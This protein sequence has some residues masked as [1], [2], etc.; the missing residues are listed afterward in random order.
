MR[1]NAPCL[2]CSKCTCSV[3]PVAAQSATGCGSPQLEAHQRPS[4]DARRFFIAGL[5][6]FG[7][8]VMAVLWR[9][10][11]GDRKVRR[12]SSRSSNRA[13]SATSRLEASEA[14]SQILED[15][16]MAA[17]A[18]LRTTHTTSTAVDSR[19]RRDALDT[20]EDVASS[21]RSIR[22]LLVPG[23]SFEAVSRDNLALLFSLLSRQGEEGGDRGDLAASAQVAV[24]DLMAPGN[25]LHCVSRDHLCAL[26]ELLAYV[27]VEALAKVSGA[28]AE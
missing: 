26:V 5:K 16:D 22:D 18:A 17:A 6:R 25:D 15:T 24:V 19:T 28:A 23:E 1:L 4:H 13:P 7:Q 12:S 2:T 3:H 9:A 10:V 8:H 20:L 14:V 11:Y 27:Q 21:L